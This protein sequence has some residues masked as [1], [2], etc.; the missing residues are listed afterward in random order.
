MRG[1]APTASRQTSRENGLA[2]APDQF[3]FTETARLAVD[4]VIFYQGLS[5]GLEIVW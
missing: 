4:G 2:V 3:T 1:R 5:L